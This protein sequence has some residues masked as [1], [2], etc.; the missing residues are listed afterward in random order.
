[1]KPALALILL[2]I[3]PTFLIA[4][5]ANLRSQAV[6]LLERAH[7]ASLAPNLPNLERTDTFRVFDPDSASREGSFSRVVIQGVGRR[8]ETTFGE[9][10]VINVWR[11]DILET[12]HPNAI[13]P[14]EV[15][16]VMQITPINLVRLDKSDVVRA[17][18]S[19]QVSGRPALCIEFD[20]IV[21]QT[22]E[23]NEICVDTSNGTIQSEKLGDD[24]IEYGDFVPFAGVLY[25][26]KITY[27]IVGRGT[28]LEIKQTMAVLE[29]A[30]ANVLA[31]P[32][33]ASTLRLCTTFRRAIGQSMPQPQPGNGGGE[34]DVV[35]RGIIGADGKI[36][37]AVVQGSPRPDLNA[38]AL[39]VISQWVF[40]PA[41][42][43][44]R[45]NPSEASFLVTFHGK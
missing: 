21:G 8:E 3:A 32:P 45:P 11:G 4:Q 34:Y 16:A 23:E 22:R 25:P 15:D 36:H 30:T 26:S 10:H 7:S 19:T 13:A 42:C 33:D 9:Y 39:N 31:A 18:T 14:S 38:E 37:D 44:G 27:S 5:D 6:T 40:S 1:M 41:M 43:N 24:L 17:I 35:V 12:T 28:V 29:D 20:T 2:L